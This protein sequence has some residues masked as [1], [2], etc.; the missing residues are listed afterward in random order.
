M[1]M[2]GSGMGLMAKP[3]LC[4][5]SL[6]AATLGYR[7]W[8]YRRGASQLS[9]RAVRVAASGATNWPIWPLWSCKFGNL[10]T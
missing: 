8:P 4:R 1:R 10:K 5:S 9:G 7:A 3:A 6:L 2:L